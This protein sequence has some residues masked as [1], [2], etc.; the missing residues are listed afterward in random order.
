M[1]AWSYLDPDLRILTDR[2]DFRGARDVV[3]CR[4]SHVSDGTCRH[5]YLDGADT[6]ELVMDGW[7]P[8]TAHCNLGN[9]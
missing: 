2:C 9:V 3:A 6:G 1:V 4:L 8:R 7:K 5:I